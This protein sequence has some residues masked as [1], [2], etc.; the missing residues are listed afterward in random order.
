MKQR[1]YWR[2]NTAVLDLI[3]IFQE[4]HKDER[5]IQFICLSDAADQGVNGEIACQVMSEDINIRGGPLW[6]TYYQVP[7][8]GDFFPLKWADPSTKDHAWIFMHE[9]K[10]PIYL[11]F[12]ENKVV[13]GTI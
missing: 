3:H 8:T 12:S 7:E 9:S 1:L 11:F 13:L 4:W 10:A 5:D 2:H 6:H